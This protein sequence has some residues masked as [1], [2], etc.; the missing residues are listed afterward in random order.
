[1]LD[2]SNRPHWRCDVAKIRQA[3]RC[4]AHRTNGAP[5]RAYAIV[6]GYVCMA[7]GGASQRARRAAERRL[8]IAI[9]DRAIWG[10][11]ARRLRELAA[12]QAARVRKTARLMGIPAEQVTTASIIV[13]NLYHGVPP[14]ADE[15]P[16]LR[17]DRRYGRR[18]LWT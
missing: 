14:L 4:H 1:M 12:W 15:A 10:A 7:H 5:C 16:P 13:C 18:L 9:V 3:R 11:R 8:C 6:G 2:L 17:L